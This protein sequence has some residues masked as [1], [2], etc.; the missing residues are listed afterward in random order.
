[1]TPAELL[2]KLDKLTAELVAANK[3]QAIAKSRYDAARLEI[4]ATL[5]GERLEP[6]TIKLTDHTLSWSRPLN[7]HAFDRAR[8]SRAF[9]IKQYPELYDLNAISLRTLLNTQAKLEPGSTKLIVEF[10]SDE[11]RYMDRLQADP[12]T[13]KKAAFIRKP[14]IGI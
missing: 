5:K 8:A 11:N 4:L 2:V 14:Q 12:P 3:A 10:Y 6:K 1:M 9:P 7:Q 13:R